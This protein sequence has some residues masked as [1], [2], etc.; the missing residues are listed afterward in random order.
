[1]TACIKSGLGH[2]IAPPRFL[3][4]LLLTVTGTLVAGSKAGWAQAV[5]IG[6]DTGAIVFLLSC[7]T[8]L[9]HDSNQIREAAARNDA[10]RIVLLGVTGIVCTVILIAI[11][12]ELSQRQQLHWPAIAL[13]IATLLLA[14]LFSNMIYALHYAHL[15]YSQADGH[16]AG[17]LD[18][19]GEGDPDYSDFIYFA[20]TLGMTFQTSDVGIP[21]RPIRRTAILHCLAAFIFNLGVLAFTINILGN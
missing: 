4:S 10:N 11:D 15:F 13:I 7:L 16:D 3:L 14:W 5:L 21:G 19:P 9:R 1:M 12:V 18:F 2:V 6:F 20:F 17:G 8:L